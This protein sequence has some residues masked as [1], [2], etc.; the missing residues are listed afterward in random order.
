MS[1]DRTISPQRSNTSE[2][3][4]E[5]EIEEIVA[6][7]IGKRGY[8]FAIDELLGALNSLA[9]ISLADPQNRTNER[10]LRMWACAIKGAIQRQEDAST[11][12]KQISESDP[13]RVRGMGIRLD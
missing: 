11:F 1:A 8:Y 6:R 7:L 12:E 3:A 13:I 9:I 10:E 2:F 5:R 4:R